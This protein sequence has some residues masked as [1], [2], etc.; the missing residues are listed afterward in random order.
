MISLIFHRLSLSDSASIAFLTAIM[1]LANSSKYSSIF[2]TFWVTFLRSRSLDFLLWGGKKI[3]SVNCAFLTCLTYW[4]T[5][6]WPRVWLRVWLLV[7][8]RDWLHVLTIAMPRT[9][10]ACRQLLGLCSRDTGVRTN[11]LFG[12]RMAGRTEETRT[13]NSGCRDAPLIRELNNNRFHINFILGRTDKGPYY[14]EKSVM[15]RDTFAGKIFSDFWWAEN[16]FKKWS[17]IYRLKCRAG[18]RT[19]LLF[20]VIPCISRGLPRC[21]IVVRRRQFLK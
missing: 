15:L 18:V 9:A 11:L 21:K 16:I 13:T 19:K 6:I 8:I 2:S 4:L 20:L 14:S 5:S 1:F 12:E 3:L 17:E 10:T 7:C